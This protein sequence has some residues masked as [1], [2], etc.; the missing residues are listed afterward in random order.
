MRFDVAFSGRER[1]GR[2]M[3]DHRRARSTFDVA[4][5]RAAKAVNLCGCG[6]GDGQV[7]GWGHRGP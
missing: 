7:R 1:S 2:D 4:R 3:P 6:C 5:D